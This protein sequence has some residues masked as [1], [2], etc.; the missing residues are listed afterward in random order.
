M[1]R[2]G[3]AG[4]AREVFLSA[5]KDADPRVRLAAL[6]GLFDQTNDLPF[7]EV[8]TAACDPSSYIRQAAMLLLARRATPSQLQ[9]LCASTDLSR[10]RAGV[11]AIG[12]RLT[13]PAWDQPLDRTTPLDASKKDAYRV[14]YAGDV[15]EVLTDRAPMGNFTASEAWAARSKSADDEAQVQLLRDRLSD[16]DSNLAKQAALY[17]RL[18]ADAPSED[19]VNALLGFPAPPGKATAIAN[20]TA[21]GLMELPEAYRKLEWSQEATR[22]NVKAGEELFKTRGCTVCHSIKEGDPGGGAPSLAGAGSR[23]TAQYLVESVIT[24]NKV[25]APLFR[26]TFAKLKNGDVVTGLITSETG[27]EAEFLLPAGIRRTVKKS[28]ITFRELQ[29]RSPMPEGLIQNPTEL[30]DLVAFLLAQK[31]TPPK[32][33]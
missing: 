6:T 16:S 27:A 5:L 9:S 22:G 21:T 1:A 33:Q 11:V 15:T 18:L 14:T 19:R 17:L 24:P 8:A 32:A 2:F 23:F 4:S 20:A 3:V 31:G 29:D 13:L 12:F 30:R 10:R 26:W 25:V 28:E 7:G